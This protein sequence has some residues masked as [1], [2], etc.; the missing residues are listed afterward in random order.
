MYQ[1]LRMPEAFLHYGEMVLPLDLL[2]KM[3]TLTLNPEP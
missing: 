1:V 2:L 3:D